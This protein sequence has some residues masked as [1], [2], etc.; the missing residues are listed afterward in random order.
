MRISED[1]GGAQTLHMPSP[2][3][4]LRHAV[5]VL[6]EGVIGPIVV[7]YVALLAAGLHG[8]LH[9]ALAWSF[10]AYFRRIRRHQR[11]STVL[12]LSTSSCSRFVRSSRT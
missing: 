1:D 11:V 9:A 10:G 12:M 5:P 2:R 3:A 6:L 8:A 4:V 7:F